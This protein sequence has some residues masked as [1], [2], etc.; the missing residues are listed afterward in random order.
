MP[1]GGL[2]DLQPWRP[3]HRTHRTGVDMDVRFWS[4]S[5]A[6]RSAFELLC[7]GTAILCEVHPSRS[8]PDRNNPQH[9]HYHLRPEG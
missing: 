4:M 9:W 8:N 6:Q 2:F 1:W 5:S 7:A 3:P